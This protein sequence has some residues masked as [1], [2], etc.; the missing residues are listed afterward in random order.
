MSKSSLSAYLG[1]RTQRKR[2]EAR[3]HSETEARMNCKS[4]FWIHNVI[5]SANR[6]DAY[7][8]EMKFAVLKFIMLLAVAPLFLLGWIMVCVGESKEASQ[9]VNV[10]VGQNPQDIITITHGPSL[11]DPVACD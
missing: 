11:L 1:F 4:I 9:N 8:I 5:I 3:E 7:R 10:R 2:W 6:I